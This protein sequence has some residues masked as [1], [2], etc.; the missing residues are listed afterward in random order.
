MGLVLSHPQ[1]CQSL[2][3]SYAITYASCQGLT[4]KGRVRLETKSGYLTTR[5]L[6]VGISRGTASHLVE[7]Q[8][9]EQENTEQ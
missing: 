6:Y 2:R 3:L 8:R 7:A 9:K 5:R 1:V 4:L